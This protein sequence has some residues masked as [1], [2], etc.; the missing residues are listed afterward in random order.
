MH[1][2]KLRKWTKTFPDEFYKEIF[3]LRKWPYKPW[4]VKPPGVIGKWAND[5]V[6]DRLA[7]GDLAELRVMNPDCLLAIVSIVTSNGCPPMLA[8][9]V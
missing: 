1:S 5:L 9:P 8:I 3:R 7:P 2:K 6:Y 4:L